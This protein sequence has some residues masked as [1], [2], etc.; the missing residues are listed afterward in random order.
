MKKLVCLCL[1]VLPLM[2]VAQ[3]IELSANA[4]GGAI[5]MKQF[6]YYGI[7]KMAQGQGVCTYGIS[8]AYNIGNHWQAGAGVQEIHTRMTAYTIGEGIYPLSVGKQTAMGTMPYL[9]AN[10]KCSKGH[11]YVYAGV[12]AGMLFTHDVVYREIE[13]WGDISGTQVHGFMAG[14]QVGYSH[15]VCGRVSLYAE[16]APTVYHI[17]YQP[18]AQ[19]YDPRETD[20]YLP[21]TVGVKCKL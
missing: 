6:S 9:Y 5:L 2:A 1:V 8:G 10:Y 4:G 3:K 12:K 14:A 16:V 20:V 15:T 18:G 17:H 19:I 21:L 11:N 13:S 7:N